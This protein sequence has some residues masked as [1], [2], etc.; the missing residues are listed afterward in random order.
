MEELVNCLR[1]VRQEVAVGYTFG[2]ADISMPKV[3][4]RMTKAQVQKLRDR[5]WSVRYVNEDGTSNIFTTYQ[6]E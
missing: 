6:G 2:V 5:G 1:D 3:D 4:N